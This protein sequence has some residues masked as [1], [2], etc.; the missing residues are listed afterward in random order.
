MVSAGV[1]AALGVRHA[2]SR[3]PGFGAFA[4]RAPYASAVL[5][6]PVGL[7]TGWLGG[8]GRHHE[9]TTLAAWLYRPVGF[10]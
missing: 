9:A 4:H 1:L 3:W 6:V 10:P 7:Y 2:A 5:I 8:Q